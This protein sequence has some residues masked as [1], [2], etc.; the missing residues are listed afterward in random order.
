MIDSVSRQSEAA[1]SA[2]VVGQARSRGPTSSA[3]L[4]RVDPA[5]L[6]LGLLPGPGVQL[7]ARGGPGEHRVSSRADLPVG[8]RADAGGPA[9][10]P[11]LSVFDRGPEV[12]ERGDQ[13]LRSASAAR[14]AIARVPLVV[15]IT[16]VLPRA[17]LRACSSAGELPRS[18]PLDRQPL[19]LRPRGRPEPSAEGSA[20]TRRASSTS[21]Q[22]MIGVAAQP[23]GR[24]PWWW[25]PAG[26]QSPPRFP[27]PAHQRESN[28]AGGGH[29]P[30]DD[31]A[32]ASKPRA[33]QAEK[34]VVGMKPTDRGPTATRLNRGLSHDR[35]RLGS[36]LSANRCN[37]R[38][39]RV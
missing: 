4:G 33:N 14:P 1:I 27:P 22:G 13:N 24:G 28:R 11:A 5:I 38:F 19:T 2:A 32:S 8:P 15:V 31:A 6:V 36:P 12:D 17:E 21:T 37:S 26:R 20:A 9:G 16:S 7:L 34:S 30:G 23:P 10:R 18:K 25:W 35:P 39:W 29:G 3:I